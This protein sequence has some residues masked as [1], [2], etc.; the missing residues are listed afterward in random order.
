MK[1]N[2][3]DIILVIIIISISLVFLIINNI[4]NKK[5]TEA[6]VYYNNKLIKKI[7]LSIDNTYNV[8]GYNGNV[9]IKVKDGKIKVEEEKSPLHLCSKKGYISKQHETIIC[10][11]NKIVI[12]IDGKDNIDTVVK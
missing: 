8:K 7:D 12:E 11:P 1:I 2:K 5:G 4:N 9:K 3:K 10:L 6:R